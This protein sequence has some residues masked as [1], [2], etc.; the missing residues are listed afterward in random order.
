MVGRKIG[1]IG[2]EKLEKPFSKPK[3]RRRNE[4]MKGEAMKEWKS[5]LKRCGWI[6]LALLLGFLILRVSANGQIKPKTDTTVA[7]IDYINALKMQRDRVQTEGN[8]I[9]QSLTAQIQL[10]ENMTQDSIRVKK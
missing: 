4:P 7:R 5:F 8:Q 3:P 1:D 9:I 6:V 2:G 10:L